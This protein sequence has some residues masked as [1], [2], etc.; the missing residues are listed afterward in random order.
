MGKDR[1]EQQVRI[2]NNKCPSCLADLNVDH[3]GLK[4]CWVCNVIIYTPK[5][6]DD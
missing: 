1:D 6:K 2:D 5:D 4:K 3:T